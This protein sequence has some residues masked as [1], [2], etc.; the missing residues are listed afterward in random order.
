[1]APDGEGEF[2]KENGRGPS[3]PERKQP[4]KQRK[5]IQYKKKKK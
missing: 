1:V 5:K 3:Q 4:R 2:P